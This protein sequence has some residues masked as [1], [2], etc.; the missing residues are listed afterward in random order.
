M[1][2]REIGFLSYPKIKKCFDFCRE[3]IKKKAIKRF[4]KKHPLCHFC[5]N[6]LPYEK[7]KNKFCSISCATKFNNTKR[8]RKH[9]LQKCLYC[10]K[11]TKSFRHKFCGKNVQYHTNLSL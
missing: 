8:K 5:K 11:I 10:N 9:K 6:D 2:H 7:R 3:N 1:N 4:K